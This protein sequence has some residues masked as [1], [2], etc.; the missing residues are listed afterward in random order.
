VRAKPRAPENAFRKKVSDYLE[1]SDI[2]LRQALRAGAGAFD[3]T[4]LGRVCDEE[5]TDQPRV[6][7]GMMLSGSS[8]IDSVKQV[9]VIRNR[10]PSAIGIEMEAHA[11]YCAVDSVIGAKPNALVIKG[12]ADHGQG[13]KNKAAQ[14]MASTMS[15]LAAMQILESI[16]PGRRV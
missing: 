10:F 3:I 13:K 16:V 4:G 12:V 5:V 6:Y 11:V 7:G 14:K 1:V 9:G 15:Y 8:V 2:A